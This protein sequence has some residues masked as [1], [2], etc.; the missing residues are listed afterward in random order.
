MV[1]TLSNDFILIKNK[2]P[3]FGGNQTQT[4]EPH[5]DTNV[6]FAKVDKPNTQQTSI[7]ST[8]P[9]TKGILLAD[10][11]FNIVLFGIEENPPQTSRLDQI[12]FDMKNCLD[13]VTKLNPEINSQSIQ[14]C[15]RLGK[16]K[17]SSS[18]PRPLLL[19]LNHSF[20]VITILANRYKTPQGI[21][22]KPDLIQQERQHNLL[23]LDER[24]KLMQMGIDKKNIKIKFSIIYLNVNKHAQVLNNRLQYYDY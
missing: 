1:T 4:S 9:A 20:D 10:C 18:R 2:L 12:K 13:V 16:Y 19:K 7:V 11:K 21:V 5:D 6:K 24:W 8:D 15:L 22:I 3:A 17:Q 14:D 23:L